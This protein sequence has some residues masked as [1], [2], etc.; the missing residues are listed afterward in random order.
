MQR[1]HHLRRRLRGRMGA[2]GRVQ[3][4]LSR[5]VSTPRL[6]D[7]QGSLGDGIQ[8]SARSR[9]IRDEKVSPGFVP[10]AVL[11]YVVFVARA[12]SVQFTRHTLFVHRNGA[13]FASILS[14]FIFFSSLTNLFSKCKHFSFN[15]L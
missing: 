2:V 10:P 7:S 14:Y 15:A 5:R 11:R 8:V 4:G 6:R 12:S 13:V 1:G 9:R 3:H